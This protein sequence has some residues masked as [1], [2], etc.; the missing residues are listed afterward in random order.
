MAEG[1]NVDVVEYTDNRPVLVNLFNLN[2]HKSDLYTHLFT[3]AGHVLSQTVG[4]TCTTR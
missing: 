3:I 4:F 1:I 2:K